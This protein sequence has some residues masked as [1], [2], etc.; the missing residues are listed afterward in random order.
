MKIVQ[1]PEAVVSEQCVLVSS[2][3]KVA[4]LVPGRALLSGGC[5]SKSRKVS[6]QLR[7]SE[8][9]SYTYI[10]VSSTASLAF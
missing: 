10:I 5:I 7:L 8:S 4:I 1:I 9:S 2:P 6:F 3:R